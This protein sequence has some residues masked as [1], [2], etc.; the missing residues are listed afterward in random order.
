MKSAR[1]GPEVLGFRVHM[2]HTDRLVR[3]G[4]PVYTCNPSTEDAE[5]GGLL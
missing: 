5:A 2:P 4:V 1:E 3:L